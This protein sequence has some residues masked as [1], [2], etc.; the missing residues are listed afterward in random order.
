[1]RRDISSGLGQ[2]RCDAGG[3]EERRGEIPLSMFG[4]ISGKGSL[5]RR[6]E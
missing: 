2:G 1:M 3:T 5:Y 6:V 4:V